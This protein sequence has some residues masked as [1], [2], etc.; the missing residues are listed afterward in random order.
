M[1]ELAITRKNGL[2]FNAGFLPKNLY[3]KK[4]LI[5]WGSEGNYTYGCRRLPSVEGYFDVL[6]VGTTIAEIRDECRCRGI[7]PE[8]VS[9]ILGKSTL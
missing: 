2:K 7:D 1:S 8:A 3:G 4:A 5:R 9:V 6:Y